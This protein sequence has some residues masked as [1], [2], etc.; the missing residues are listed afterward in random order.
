VNDR[1]K[2]TYIGNVPLIARAVMARTAKGKSGNCAD[3][4]R[5]ISVKLST[6]EIADEDVAAFLAAM[7]SD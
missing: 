7:E 5:N 3:Y 1:T 6:L 4:V 2:N